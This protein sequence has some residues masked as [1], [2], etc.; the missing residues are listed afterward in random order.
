MRVR[1]CAYEPYK[2]KRDALPADATT[3]DAAT[4]T[5]IAEIHSCSRYPAVTLALAT[6][7]PNSL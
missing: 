1:R 7:S 3:N 5:A 2:R 6:I 4:Q